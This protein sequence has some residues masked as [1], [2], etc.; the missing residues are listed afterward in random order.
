MS[1]FRRFSGF[2]LLCCSLVSLAACGGGGSSSTSQTDANQVASLTAPIGISVTSS[3]SKNTITWQSVSGATSYNIYWS[4]S[5]IINKSTSS[6]IIN[7]SSPYIHSNLVDSQKYYYVITALKDNSESEATV[8]VEIIASKVIA[9]D[10]SGT[11][12]IALK[13][14]GSVWTWN[15][16][17]GGFSIPTQVPGLTSIIKVA[18]G[19]STAGINYMAL[20]S[21]GTLWAW[22]NNTWG[23]LGNGTTVSSPI[24]VRVDISDVVAI[25][26]TGLGAFAVKRDG[27][28]WGWGYNGND[29]A[30]GYLAG[31]G[32][33]K[34]SP[35]QIPNLAG[36]VE[37]RSLN[38][39]NYAVKTDGTL[40][41]WGNEGTS[42]AGTAVNALPAL[43]PAIGNV[44][45]V[46]APYW[47]AKDGS[48]WSWKSTIFG[49]YYFQ[50]QYSE[51]FISTPTKL[52]GIDNVLDISLH[53]FT[54][55]KADGTVWTAALDST[56]G[57]YQ[58]VKV[59][60]LDDAI[61]TISSD[62]TTFILRR[63]GTIVTWGLEYSGNNNTTYTN[64]VGVSG[65]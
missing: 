14:D 12:E 47:I 61:A 49:N 5:P 29:G 22:G 16:S 52:V 17:T 15:D 19:T 10:A 11:N 55:V 58:Y 38:W 40:W 39:V 31:T 46:F 53:P 27:T 21:D 20:K 23:Q 62:F 35:V 6:K 30:L 54:V 41:V 56:Q 63:D 28:V 60:P 57:T 50:G 24:P 43:V 51:A 34:S 36:V 7:A 32:D 9:M 37:I 25:E 42:V 33:Y 65:I 48:V 64:P 45:T 44:K 26:S 2:A 18:V 4:T 3:A 8:E 59:N 13:S 1:V